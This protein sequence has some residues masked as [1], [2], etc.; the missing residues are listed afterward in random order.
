VSAPTGRPLSLWNVYQ[1]GL[2]GPGALIF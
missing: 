1:Y 2:L